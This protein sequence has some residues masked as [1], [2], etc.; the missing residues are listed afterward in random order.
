MDPN[1]QLKPVLTTLFALATLTN[2][3]PLT[4]VTAIIAVIAVTAV[5]AVSAINALG[6][7]TDPAPQNSLAAT[8]LV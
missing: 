8:E 7:V 1:T 4:A 5:T 2:P 3:S 6:A